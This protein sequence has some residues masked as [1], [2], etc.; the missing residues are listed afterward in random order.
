M[1]TRSADWETAPQVDWVESSGVDPST[2]PAGHTVPPHN[3]V[4]DSRVSGRPEIERWP[5]GFK[6]QQQS[7]TRH[8]AREQR[9]FE[10]GEL[11]I[12]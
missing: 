5:R 8:F 11:C 1:A 9:S 6:V 7:E 12:A 2:G 4:S 10:L 3:Q